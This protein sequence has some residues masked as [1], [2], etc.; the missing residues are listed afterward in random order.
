MQLLQWIERPGIQR[1][2][3]FMVFCFWI[4]LSYQKIHV[5]HTLHNRPQGEHFWAQV[6]RASMA[7]TYYKDQ[8]PFWLPRTHRCRGDAEGITAGEFPLVPYVVSRFYTWFGFHEIYHRLFVLGLTLTGFLFAF[9]LSARLIS[10]PAWAM[11]AAAAWVLSPNLIYYSVSFLPDT[12]SL[13]LLTI[14]LYFL[15]RRQTVLRP[16]DYLGYTLFLSL[17]TLIKISSLLPG[18]GVA[19]ALLLCEGKRHFPGF[20][21]KLLLAASMLLPVVLAAAWVLY[22]RKLL[23]E[24]NNSVFLMQPLPPRNGEHFREGMQ[25][26]G[27]HL[28]YF[29]QKSMFWLLGGITL[30]GLVFIRRTRPFLLVAALFTYAGFYALFLL[31]FEK[32][33]FHFYYWPPFQI[34]VFFHIAWFVDLLAKSR[35]PRWSIA[36][37]LAG[38]MLFLNVATNHIAFNFR[39]RWEKNVENNDRYYQLE[40]QLDALGISYQERVFSYQDPTVNGFLYLMNRKGWSANNT[41]PAVDLQRGLQ[42]CT[43]AVLNDTSIV[44]NTEFKPYFYRRM[45]KINNLVIYQLQHAQ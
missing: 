2:L 15:L 27:G 12:P 8:A 16:P 26:F 24:Y 29:Y 10:S 41:D 3:A 40:P 19:M 18:I 21:H 45:A 39:P 17:A 9:L 23:H 31:L 33:P 34:G 13:A 32:S 14:S 43:Y 38:G 28:H 4:G 44:E 1:W 6:D 11:F 37:L 7:L 36:L 5:G 30:I 25:L 42:V 22:T 20:R 35:L